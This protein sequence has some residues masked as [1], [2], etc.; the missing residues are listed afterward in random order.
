MGESPSLWMPSCI[1]S[2][3]VELNGH[4]TTSDS[5]A[6]LLLEALDNSG[7]VEALADNNA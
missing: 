1:G 5:G 3:R 4:R 7:V 6:L 2:I